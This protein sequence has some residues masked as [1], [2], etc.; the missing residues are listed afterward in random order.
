MLGV[1]GTWTNDGKDFVDI[2]GR[3]GKL[4]SDFDAVNG[5]GMASGDYSVWGYGLSAKYGKH[6]QN[7]KTTFEPYAKLAYSSLR[8]TD[9]SASGINIHQDSANSLYGE[10]GMSVSQQ[11]RKGSSV[12]L[13]V[14]LVH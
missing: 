7:G 6:Y 13:N 4:E 1:Y 11:I 12:F 5:T 14:A 10:L 3:V 2:V 9:Y 8:G